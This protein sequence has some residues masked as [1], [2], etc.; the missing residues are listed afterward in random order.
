MCGANVY[1]GHGSTF[2]RNDSKIFRYCSSKCTKAAKKRLNPRRLRHSKHHRRAHNKELTVDASLEFEKIRNR[3]EKYDRELYAQTVKAMKKIQEIQ[4]ARKASFYD[5]R[6][7]KS[8]KVRKQ[9]V[10]STVSKNVDLLVNP[11]VAKRLAEKNLG[12]TL[13][14]KEAHE[15]IAENPMLVL[16]DRAKAEIEKAKKEN[17]LKKHSAKKHIQRVDAMSDE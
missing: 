9:L 13:T 7:K 12:I 4:D 6:M 10:E 11:I 1:P 3:P 15:K 2:A 17:K 8:H 5:E 14:A 16:G